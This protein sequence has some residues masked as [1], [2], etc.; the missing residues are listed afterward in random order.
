[1]TGA[2]ADTHVVYS[3][4]VANLTG[5]ARDGADPLAPTPISD[6]EPFSWVPLLDCQWFNL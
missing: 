6:Q 2:H 3:L 5:A 4:A 1:M